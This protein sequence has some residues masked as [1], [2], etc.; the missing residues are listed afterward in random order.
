[1]KNRNIYH[2]QL[3]RYRQFFITNFFFWTRATDFS[4]K[5][6]HSSS[7]QFLVPYFGYT[8]C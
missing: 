1:M 3:V 8:L 6:G 2:V 5:R 7:K 4:D